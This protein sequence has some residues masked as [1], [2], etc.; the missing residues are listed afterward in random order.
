MLETWKP[1]IGYEG[2]Y[3]VSNLG[4]V[5]SLARVKSCGHPGSKQLT[6]ERLMTIREDRNG[7]KRVKLS[8]DGK[9]KLITLH[10]IVAMSFVDNPLNKN[11]VNH[12]D[13][14][15]NNNIPSNLEWVTRSENVQHA[16]NK[17][18]K[19]AIKGEVNNNAKLTESDVKEIRELRK[20]GLTLRSIADK[21]KITAA[22]VS[23][24]VNYKTW[25]EVL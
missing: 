10:R 18:L 12:I 20:E 19:L 21:Y 13:G 2:I 7:Y 9:S 17:K 14:N 11:E 8:K 25:K 16:F 15:K 4:R 1:V 23:E 22:N 3:E 24:I 6:K 5:K